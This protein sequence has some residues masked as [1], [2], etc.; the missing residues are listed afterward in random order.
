[1]KI[2]AQDRLTGAG[3]FGSLPTFFV[4]EAPHPH[5]LCGVPSRIGRISPHNSSSPNLFNA[6][7]RG[8]GPDPDELGIFGIILGVVESRVSQLHYL[9]M[10]H[11]HGWLTDLPADLL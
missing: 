1:L 10:R 5:I 6:V 2:H 7:T 4:V 8:H 11:I 9:A 3:R